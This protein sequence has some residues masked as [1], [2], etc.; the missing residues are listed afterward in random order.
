MDEEREKFPRLL[1]EAREL[2]AAGL[3]I[4][5]IL[6]ALR[7]RSPSIIQ[8]IKVIRDLLSIS[9]GE[10]KLLVHRSRTWSDMRDIFSEVH[11]VAETEYQT[12]SAEV[13]GNA[14]KVRIDLA[15]K[16]KRD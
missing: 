6:D 9:L 7:Q 14:R 5:E 10:A 13:T 11:D 2:Q 4:D 1:A 8:S 12:D 15:Q 3:S 16:R